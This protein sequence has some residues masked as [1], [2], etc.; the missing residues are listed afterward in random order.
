MKQ[1]FIDFVNALMEAA[2]EVVEKRMT[3]NVRAYLEAL[4]GAVENKPDLTENGKVILK[5]MQDNLD[6]VTW[7]ARDVAEG[8]GISSRGVAGTLRKMVND[9]FVEKLGENPA[10]YTLTE[11]GKNYNID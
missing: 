10:V 9:G 11:K 6:S 7:K 8:I 5:H 3:E 1:E 2:P 4:N